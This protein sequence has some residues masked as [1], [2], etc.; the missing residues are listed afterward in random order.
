MGGLALGSDTTLIVNGEPKQVVGVTP[1]T[2]FGLAVGDSFVLA[3][4]YCRPNE[5]RRDVFDVTVMGRLQPG[6]TLERASAQ[7]ETA[8]PGIRLAWRLL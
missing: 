1:P 8:S 4:P 7:L 2:F 6:W 5:L 3:V